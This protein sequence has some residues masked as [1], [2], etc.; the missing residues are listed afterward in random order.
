MEDESWVEI[1]G[2]RLLVRVHGE[3]QPVL[4][5]NG[6]GSHTAMWEPLEQSLPGVQAI[7][8]DAPGVGRSPATMPPPSISTLAS[9]AYGV[10]RH[11]G[12][13]QVDVVGYSLGG[14]VAQTLAR[15]HP[16]RVRRLVL[17]ATMPGMGCI[18]GGWSSM[19]HLYNPLRYMSRIYYSRTIG[20]L[21]GGQAK[22]DPTFIEV[23]GR[24]RRAHQP[25]VYGYYAQMAVVSTW[26]SLR[27]LSDIEAPTLVI[28]GGDDPMMPPAN[29]ALIARRIPTARLI[30]SPDDG[31]LLLFDKKSPMMGAVREFLTAPSLAESTAWHRGVEVTPELE[32]D[33]VR[34]TRRGMFPWGHL[35]AAYRDWVSSQLGDCR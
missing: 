34:T 23:H 5:I 22:T 1:D 19:I 33:M 35:S 25:N 27:W 10:L 4:L 9:L 20:A 28:V 29:G 7:S 30:V 24:Q 14:T 13:D 11:L 17:A 6:I 32:D 8:F 21:A 26:S 12:L 16:E 15:E 2:F 31:H 18:P 3:G